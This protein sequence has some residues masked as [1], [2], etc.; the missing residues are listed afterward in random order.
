MYLCHNGLGITHYKWQR[1]EERG[2]LLVLLKDLALTLFYP[3]IKEG[4]NGF[5]PNKEMNHW[6]E[7]K[8][9]KDELRYL[10]LRTSNYSP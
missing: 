7:Q 5:R 10:K 1:Y 2:F 6:E 4:K 3:T 9:K 8:Q